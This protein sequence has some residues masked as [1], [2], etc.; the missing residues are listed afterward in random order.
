MEASRSE[1][2]LSLVT[3]NESGKCMQMIK[4]GWSRR[5]III[6]FQ[7]RT[8]AVACLQVVVGKN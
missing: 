8:F 7:N 5:V 3:L 6:V 2:V 4:V 1:F